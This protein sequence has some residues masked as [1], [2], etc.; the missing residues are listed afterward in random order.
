M[1]EGSVWND[2]DTQKLRVYWDKDLPVKDIMALLNNR[3]T[4]NSIIGKA[5]RLHLKRRNI[6]IEKITVD[7]IAGVRPEDAKIT[8]CRWPI[9][10]PKTPEFR[11][12]GD[13]IVKGSYCDHHRKIAYKQ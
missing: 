3:Y 9:G 8:S 7:D 6:K 10:D 11:F 1:I 5:R 2:I 12:C 13:K 4:K